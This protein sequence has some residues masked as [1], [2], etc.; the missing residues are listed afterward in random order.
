MQ[1]ARSALVAA[2]VVL[3]SAGSSSAAL[4]V[5]GS[6]GGA[7]TGVVLDNLNWL[8]LGAAGGVSPLTGM[9]VNLS[10][11]A[12][13]V[14]G[15]V[16]GQYAAP[17]LSGGNGTGF[18]DPLGTTQ[19]NGQ[20]DSTYIAAGATRD[21]EYALVE[22][23]MPG[24][25]RYLGLLWGSVDDYNTLTFYAGATLLGSISGVDVVASPN[26]NQGVNGTLYVNITSDIAFDRIV[27]TSTR[28]T[29]EIDNI[30]FSETPPVTEPASMALLGV[31]LAG[32]GTVIRKRR[33]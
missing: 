25:Q 21:W 30:A 29:F 5:S 12:Q 32:A 4:I 2:T 27:A 28:P 20:N 16:L 18:G 14:H 3:A 6:I 26:G 13:A 10:N 22:L 9:V 19:P 1:F 15:S 17:F 11:N 7:P 23:L 8:P 24:P 33:A 31:A